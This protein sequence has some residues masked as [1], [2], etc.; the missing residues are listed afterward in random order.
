MRYFIQIS[1]YLHNVHNLT[2]YILYK[3]LI[4][5]IRKLQLNKTNSSGTEDSF[6]DLSLLISNDIIACKI[7][8]KWDE[9]DIDAVTVAF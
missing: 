1:K 3:R 2:I 6:L 5:F 4:N 7:Y 8:N 9:F